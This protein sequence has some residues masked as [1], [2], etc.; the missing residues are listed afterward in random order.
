MRYSELLI[1]M[2]AMMT[3]GMPKKSVDNQR[4]TNDPRCELS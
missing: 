1:R 4:P 2:A 3:G